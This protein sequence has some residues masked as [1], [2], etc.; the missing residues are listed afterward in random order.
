MF[1]VT[2]FKHPLQQL[3]FKLSLDV[4]TRISNLVHNAFR[5]KDASVRYTHIKVTRAKGISLMI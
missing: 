4:V 1:A 5:K 3:A 2:Q